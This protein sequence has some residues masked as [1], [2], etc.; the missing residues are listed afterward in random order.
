MFS[1]ITSNLSSILPVA[2]I[3]LVIALAGLGIKSCTTSNELD[4]TKQELNTTV[5]NY[6]ALKATAKLQNDAVEQLKVA[7]EEAKKKFEEASKEAE[8]KN[9]DL[10]KTI[11]NLKAAQGKTCTDAVSLAKEALMQ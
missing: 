1:L 11:G 5:A 2:T 7:S 9:K 3:V 4:K 6:N 10:N 8:Q